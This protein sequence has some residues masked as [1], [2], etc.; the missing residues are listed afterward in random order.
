MKIFSAAQVREWDKYTIA[1]EPVS[2]IELMERASLRVFAWILENGWLKNDFVVVCG[3]GNNAGDGLALARMLSE[4]N[5]RVDL[6]LLANPQTGS[7]DFTINYQ[8]LPAGIRK[9]E[10]FTAGKET[11]SASNA[12]ESLFSRLPKNNTILIDAIF[13]SGLNKTP[14]GIYATAIDALNDSG[15]PVLSIDLPSGLHADNAPT[16]ETIV[17]ATYTLSFQVPKLASLLPSGAPFIGKQIILDIGL[18][19]GFENDSESPYQL[20]DQQTIRRIYRPRSDHSHK[21][22]NGH[23]LLI[24]GSFGKMGAAVLAASACLR[25]GAGL[26]TCHIPASGYGIMQSVLPEAMVLTDYNSS[27]NTRFEGDY[28]IYKAIGIGPGIG[29]AKETADLLDAVLEQSHRPV[30]IDA[31]ALNII[32]ADK[33]LLRLIPPGSVLTP[34]PKEFER[35][36]GDTGSDPER[37][38]LALD[39]A[40]E[41]ESI[42]VLKG[43]YTF[44]AT[45]AGK[46]FFN[47][48][49]N[50]GLA[51]GGTGDTLTG[52]I[53]A[54][55]AQGYDAAEASILGVYIHGLAAD[56]LVEG[57]ES[58]E[59]ML[60]GDLVRGLGKAFHQVSRY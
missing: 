6:L 58:R 22:N 34:H 24:A 27:F 33:H 7:A 46:G 28:S 47:Q 57:D 16:N 13:G 3:K 60:A 23:A 36:F 37:L 56:I 41:L 32:G 14:E 44:I 18:D 50:G 1:H 10:L 2:S 52:I 19:P 42:I 11:D 43:H 53:T 38:Q 26:L 48:T 54:L 35:L 4:N 31:D 51:K 55:L 25:S 39:K 49:G 15:L 29:T 17:R 40:S 9:T 21:G 59:S 5:C 45:P 12:F 8:R 30:V 20:V